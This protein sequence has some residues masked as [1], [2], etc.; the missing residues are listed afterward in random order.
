MTINQLRSCIF[1]L[2][3]LL[4]S[5][6]LGACNSEL[7]IIVPNTEIVAPALK[8]TSAIPNISRKLIEGVYAVQQGKARFGDTVILKHDRE[9]LSIFCQKNSTYMVLRSGMK[10]SSILYAGYWRNAQ[11]PQ[12][13]LCT[14]EIRNKDGAGDILQTIRP[15][16]LTIR[17]AVGGSEVQPN[18]PLILEYVR[19]LFERKRERTD[20]KFWIIAHRGGGRNSDRLPFSENSTE[21]IKFAGKLGANGVE[22]D[23]RLTKDGIPVLYHDENLNSRLVDGEY[24][25]GAIGNYTFAQLQ[26]LCRLKNGER[27]PTLD[28]ALRTIVDSTNLTSVWLDIKE[29]AAIEKIIA[30]QKTY[31]ERAQLLQAAGKRD[32][33]EIFSGLATDEIYQAFVAH[34]EHLQ[35][36]SICE[37]SISQT[38]KANSKVFAPRWTLGSLQ[39]E[40]NSLHSENRRAFVWT[41]D[42]P[43]FIVQFLNEGNYDGILTNYPTVVA[44]NYYIRR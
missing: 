18:E 23:I 21:L 19:P 7:R 6:Q 20:G 28:D 13:G 34:P 12:T 37:L 24:M 32:T 31:I 14:L 8:G 16:T 26:V 4:I 10:D 5:W 17:G 29:P 2:T 39:N 27:I 11:S 3:I 25:V 36:P 33:L 38:Q 1:I 42:Q 9:S 40:V 30:M 15:Q 43:E 44:Y 22:I 35:I 41:L